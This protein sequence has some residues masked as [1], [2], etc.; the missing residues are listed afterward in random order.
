[1][2][3]ILSYAQDQGN[4][5]STFELIFQIASIV[6]MWKMFEKA[7]EDGWPALIPFY[8]AY[9]LCGITM[10]NPWY[11]LRLFVAII[12]VV[13]WV[14]AFYFYYQMC[15]AAALAYGR[16]ESWTWGYFFLSPIFYCLTGFGDAEYYGP[17]GVNDNRT[18]EARGARTVDF[19]V[20]KNQPDYREPEY[21]PPEPVPQE[22][23]EEEVVDFVFDQPEE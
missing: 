20:V 17:M 4:G 10:G 6:G 21:M 11:W 3:T 22:K 7:G 15:R 19:D 14:A 13:G 5:A 8:N 16:P 18:G 9:K 23:A 2:D 1:M 12:P